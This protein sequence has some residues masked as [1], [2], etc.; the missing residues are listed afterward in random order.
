MQGRQ[1]W[2]DPV[3][4]CASCFSWSYKPS[5]VWVAVLCRIGP[6]GWVL[7]EAEGRRSP[8]N[9]METCRDTSGNGRQEP[10]KVEIPS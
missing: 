4:L 8:H 7:G 10:S 5:C 3:V 2:Q 1:R 9:D 6:K